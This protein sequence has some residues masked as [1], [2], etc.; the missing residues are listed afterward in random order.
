MRSLSRALAAIAA[1]A[2]LAGACTGATTQPSATPGGASPSAASAAPAS[3]APSAQAE[4]VTLTYF[5][6]SAAPDHL[7]D[8]D[9]IVQAFEQKHPNIS[10]E[11]QTAAY[12]DYFTKLQ[13]QVAGGSAPDTF[14]L[15]YENSVAYANSGALLDLTPLA[16][17]DSDFDPSV[18]YPKAYEVF[19]ADGK[20]FGVPEQFS[21]VVL[22]YNKD[23]FDAAGV[24][25]PDASW[26]WT[27]EQAA[28]E[29]LTD[30]AN[31]I[32]G[33]FQPIQFFEFY[34]VLAQNGGSFF[35]EDQTKS[36]FNDAKGV[37]AA[38][39][40]IGKLDKTMP[41]DAFGPD[42]D[43]A[44]FKSGKLA[45]WHT[46][47][48]LFS[49]LADAPFTW[50]ISV[51]P[52]NVQKA[53]HFFANAVVA[54]AST[55][56]PAEAWAWLRFLTSSDEAV[57]VR[58]DASWEL[59]AVADQSLFAPYLSQ[60]PPENREAVFEALSDIVTPPVIEQQQQMQDIVTQALEKARLGQ[61]SVPDALNEAATQVD[62]LLQ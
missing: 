54:S 12:A 15:N 51:E 36:T 24:A 59:A 34:K 44:L 42:Q 33:H 56:H 11:V 5:T 31:G 8:L 37:E 17:G 2:I 20:Q 58:L 25:Y 46:G 32:W 35:N 3:P 29:Q 22:F 57:K 28:A 43:S 26:T 53:H 30:K 23:L 52:G 45:M 16:A 39:W 49:A 61:V 27:D 10:I 48:W 9:A 21:D 62:A 38:E 1:T 55:E 47:I 13:T 41:S 4:D 19:S 60:T 14:E 18:Y 50:D 40:L 6:F 7:E